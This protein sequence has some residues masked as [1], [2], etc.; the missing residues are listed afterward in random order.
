ALNE[1][2]SDFFGVVIAAR[3]RD[4]DPDWAVGKEIFINDRKL[5]GLR[6]LKDPASVMAR[7]RDDEGKVVVRPYPAHVK[8]QFKTQNP[9]GPQ[10]DRCFVHTN[11]MIPGH[12]MYLIAEAIGLDD[13]ERLLY[14]TLTQYLTKTSTFKIFRT[15]TLKAC[16]QLFPSPECTKVR[17]AFAEVGL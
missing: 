3:H 4:S 6:N 16:R 5:I 10:N 17:K 8:D 1:A 13:A 2:F 7:I 9:C 12:A 14:L 11:S 15:Q